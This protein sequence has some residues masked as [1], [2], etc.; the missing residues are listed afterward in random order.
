M[1]RAAGAHGVKWSG[2]SD[3]GVEAERDGVSS[4]DCPYKSVAQVRIM[5]TQMH[6]RTGGPV[7]GDHSLLLPKAL[8]TPAE[9]HA[10]PE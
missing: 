3:G 9:A 2:D 8:A 5:V 4:W 10:D 7:F 1:T 6:A